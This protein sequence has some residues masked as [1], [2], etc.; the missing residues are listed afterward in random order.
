MQENMTPLITVQ[1]AWN[2]LEHDISNLVENPVLDFIGFLKP[3]LTVNAGIQREDV[4]VSVSFEVIR[5]GCITFSHEIIPNI[6]T[7]REIYGHFSSFDQRICPWENYIDEELRPYYPESPLRFR[8]NTSMEIPD[9]T[10]EFSGVS[11][12][13]TPQGYVLP[14]IIFPNPAI[15]TTSAADPKLAGSEPGPVGSDSSSDSWE[16]EDIPDEAPEA[17]KLQMMDI[18][19][20]HKLQKMKQA[21]VKGLAITIEIRAAYVFDNQA[22]EAIFSREFKVSQPPAHVL[23]PYQL[24]Y[25]QIEQIGMSYHGGL[26]AS[27]IW[28]DQGVPRED[29]EV[30]VYKV[31]QGIYVRY[32]YRKT[33]ALDVMNLPEQIQAALPLGWSVSFGTSLNPVDLELTQR[34][35]NITADSQYGIPW[36]I[37][38]LKIPLTC[39]FRGKL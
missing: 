21:I 19:D 33:P 35:M 10:R 20:A 14:P 36:Q 27:C 38:L 22:H 23:E 2:L 29:I 8:L 18:S 28:T 24:A 15:N 34:L 13:L 4:R 12:G 5:D 30:T 26:P 37:H 31:G 6:A 9:T 32:G 17:Q 25:K 39:L 11:G 3:G 16:E 1:A 7:W